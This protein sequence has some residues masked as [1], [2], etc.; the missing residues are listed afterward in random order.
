MTAKLILHSHGDMVVL[1]EFIEE[2]RGRIIDERSDDR[3]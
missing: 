2:N 3:D 1:R